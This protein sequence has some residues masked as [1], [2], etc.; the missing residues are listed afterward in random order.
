MHHLLEKVILVSL[1]LLFILL[2][3]RA[4]TLDFRQPEVNWGVSFDLYYAAWLN[5][6]DGRQVY[7]EILDD[8]KINNIRLSARWDKIEKVQGV[9]DWSDLDWQLAVAKDHGVKVLLAVGRK[10]PRWPECFEPTWYSNLSTVEREAALL[11]FVE[12]VIERYQSYDNIVAW[13]VENEPLVG[14]FGICRPPDRSQLKKEI[15]LVKSLDPSRSVV[16]TDSGELS[17]WLKAASLTDILGTTMYRVVQNEMI[18]YWRWPLPAA[19]YYYK[20]DLIKSLTPIQK[21]IV[22]ELQAEPWSEA[23]VENFPLEEQYKSMSLE[24]FKSNLDYVERAG[25][26]TVYLWGVEWWYWLKATK[27][28]PD[29]WN[30]A[31]VLWQ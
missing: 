13:Q 30:E 11:Q 20:A 26:D 14:W 17:A 25:F 5:G 28:V 7:S 3:F 10:L 15:A 12:Q 9:Y 4:F 1:L 6:G 18:G 23:G 19:Y 24:Q 22:T 2:G 27:N 16:V 8:L 29:F 31:K 21:V